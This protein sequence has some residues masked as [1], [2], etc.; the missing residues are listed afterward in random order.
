[1]C[2]VPDVMSSEG[3]SCM[4]K[5][6]GCA[7]ICRETPR[8]GV[9]CDCRPGFELAK[10]QRDCTL[11]CN[12]G[13]GGCQHTCNDTDTRPVCMCHPKYSLQEDGR[14]CVE[15]HSLFCCWCSHCVHT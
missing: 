13:N 10:N 7:H 1:F 4:N 12:H 9:A 8:G 2:Y 3:Q 5:E 6:H 11:T 14:T 15:L